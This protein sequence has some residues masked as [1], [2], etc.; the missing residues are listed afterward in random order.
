MILSDT[1]VKYSG[2]IQF[3]PENITK[4]HLLQAEWKRTAFI[5]LGGD[6]CEYYA[7]FL[8]K[9]F[10]LS[11]IKPLRDAHISFINDHY[12]RD[13]SLPEDEKELMWERIKSEFD[14]KTIDV[15]LNLNVHTNGKHWWLNVDHAFRDE[16]HSIRSELGLGR[17]HSGLHMSIGLVN[18]SN[19]DHSNYIHE[20]HKKGIIKLHEYEY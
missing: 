8:K 3:E 11:L 12:L 4:K 14:G 16:I 20:L 6:L 15:V 18:D 5:L 13:S 7:W 2:K 9:R 1:L 19:R 10:N 17:P